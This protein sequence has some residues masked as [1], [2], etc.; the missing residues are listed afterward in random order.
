MQVSE[1]V[2]LKYNDGPQIF[3]PDNLVHE[4]SDGKKWL[5]LR[6]SSAV[7]A[8][9]ILGHLPDFKN[10][11]NPSL[12]ASPQIKALQDKLK[13]AVLQG[14]QANAQKQATLFGDGEDDEANPAQKPSKAKRHALKIAPGTVLVEVGTTMVE[15]KTPN[16]WKEVDIIVPM[17]AGP[18]TAICNFIMEDVDACV[19]KGKKRTYVRSGNYAKKHKGE[20]ENEDEDE[21]D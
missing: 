19:T 6:A 14:E 11:K 7:I 8:K 4:D 15:L 18:L 5:K 3:V 1:V 12:T 16:S 9:L 21:E 2:C 20:V 10:Q 13:T 17:E